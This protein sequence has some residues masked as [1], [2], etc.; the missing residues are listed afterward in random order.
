MQS[1]GYKRNKTSKRKQTNA[2]VTKFILCTRVSGREW[3][4]EVSHSIKL[5][6]FSSHSVI[7]PNQENRITNPKIKLH[8]SITTSSLVLHDDRLQEHTIR[9]TKW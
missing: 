5:V 7:D 6:D 8:V 1:Y 9:F 4:R 2:Y 3:A